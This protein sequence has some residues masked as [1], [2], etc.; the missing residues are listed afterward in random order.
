MSKPKNTFSCLFLIIFIGSISSFFIITMCGENE[1]EKESRYEK[2]INDTFIKT[3]DSELI[4]KFKSL[5]TVEMFDSLK[6]SG[7]LCPIQLFYDNNSN[8]YELQAIDHFLSKDLIG[9]NFKVTYNKDFIDF[10]IIMSTKLEKVG[11]YVDENNQKI[12]NANSTTIEIYIYDNK[13][14]KLY[15][16]V[17]N[18][19]NSPKEIIHNRLETIGSNWNSEDILKY[20]MKNNFLEKRKVNSTFYSDD[21]IEYLE[22]NNFLGLKINN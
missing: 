1:Y 7:K 10:Y 6:L 4:N 20:L 9:N 22:K 16:V 8:S 5:N 21:Y 17:S 14:K 11:N 2:E 13:L 12:S 18:K 19:G 3:L 15:F